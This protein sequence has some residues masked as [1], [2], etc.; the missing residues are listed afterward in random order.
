MTIQITRC[1]ATFTITPY[2]RL[3]VETVGEFRATVDDLLADNHALLVLNLSD[4]PYIDSCGLGAIVHAFVRACQ[5]GGTMKLANVEGRNRRLLRITHLLTVVEV[6][7]SVDAAVHSYG[8]ALADPEYR[9]SMSTLSTG[10][11]R[12]WP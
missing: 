5:R 7:D 1:G 3:T 10:P 12:R 11:D 2:G 4:V 6:Y 8:P 9:A